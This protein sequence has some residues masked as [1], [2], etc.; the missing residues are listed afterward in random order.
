[1]YFTFIYSEFHLGNFITQSLAI[2]TSDPHHYYLEEFY[3]VAKL[4]MYFEIVWIS[5]LVLLILPQTYA[6]VPTLFLKKVS[7]WD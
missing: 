5:L 7:V 6:D 2:F 4:L 1:M 3:I